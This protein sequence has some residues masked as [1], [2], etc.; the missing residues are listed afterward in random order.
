MPDMNPRPMHPPKRVITSLRTN[1][2]THRAPRIISKKIQKRKAVILRA[3]GYE[4]INEASQLLDDI[5]EP[6]VGFL[7]KQKY[8]H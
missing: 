3:R 6:K 7:R 4:S 2:T 8:A 1:R 5:R